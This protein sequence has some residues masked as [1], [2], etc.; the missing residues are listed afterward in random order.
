MLKV[1][2]VFQICKISRTQLF[3]GALDL[4]RKLKSANFDFSFAHFSDVGSTF[5]V[6]IFEFD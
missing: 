5:H 1:Q 3:N 6:F 2:S 4:T